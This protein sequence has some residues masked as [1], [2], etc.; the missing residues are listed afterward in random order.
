MLHTFAA[1]T[2]DYVCS[3]ECQLHLPHAEADG[4]QILPG[5]FGGWIAK[6]QTIKLKPTALLAAGE[7]LPATTI[8]Y[9]TLVRSQ[10]TD[11][12]S[13]GALSLH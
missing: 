9:D 7:M 13:P 2:S 1:G 8:H 10:A 5:D 3:R 11:A 4:L 12:G 6:P